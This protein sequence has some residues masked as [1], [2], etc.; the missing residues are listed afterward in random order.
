MKLTR[1][2]DRVGVHTRKR[3][4]QAEERRD[5]PPPHHQTVERLKGHR[6]RGRGQSP[7]VPAFPSVQATLTLQNLA[8][9]P[10]GPRLPLCTACV[11]IRQEPWSHQLPSQPSVCFQCSAL[12]ESLA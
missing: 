8:P 3:G 12:A 2:E 9:R 7:E 10:G 6:F 5:C 11:A 1:Q 4:S